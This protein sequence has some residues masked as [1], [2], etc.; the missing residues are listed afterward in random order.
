MGLW[1]EQVVPR[2]TNL[3]LGAEEVHRLRARTCEGLAGEVLEIGFGSGLNVEHCPPEVTRVLA[4][5]P[6]DVAW[7]IAER[8][9]LGG[10]GPPVVRVGLDG[11]R[12]ALPDGS[13]D[14]ALSTFTLCTIPDVG[15]ALHEVRRV[16]RPGGLLHF[17]EHGLAPDP[18]VA[19]WQR[20]LTPLQRRLAAGCHLD[21]PVAA[22]VEGAGLVVEDLEAFYLPGAIAVGKVLG[23]VYL[24]R[25][26]RP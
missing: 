7:R 14:A 2:A 3:L 1:S 22:S 21:R 16:L 9:H 17:L 12:L 18:G 5:E 25:A 13:V 23:F 8:K 15:A 19:R 4:V 11:Q 26:A 6:S 20:R 10:G 24:G